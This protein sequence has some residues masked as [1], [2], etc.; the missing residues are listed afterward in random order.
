VSTV[1]RD[2]IERR[3]FGVLRPVF[4]AFLLVIT[5]FP[6]YYMVMLS[7]RPL[8]A[9]L[10][11]PGALFPRLGEIDLGTYKDVLAPVEDGGQ[12]FL[13]FIKNSFLIAIGTVVLTLL[14]SIPGAYAV[15][16]LEFFGRRQIGAVF[17]GVYFFPAILLAIP[18]FVF[19]TRIQQRAAW[20]L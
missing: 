14:V 18:L 19:F 9:V 6:F 4:I 13:N 8:D 20:S 7:F 17:L 2:Q 10:Q 15:S 5:L 11:D 1:N 12:G 3:V 16:R